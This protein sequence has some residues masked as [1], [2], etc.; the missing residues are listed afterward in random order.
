MKSVI[1]CFVILICFFSCGRTEK[2]VTVIP[3]DIAE[4]IEVNPD[5][6][7]QRLNALEI[8]P[9]DEYA[10][11]RYLLYY[12]EAK[13]KAQKD[14]SIDIDVISAFNYFKT[15]GD[16]CNAAL[17]AYYSGRVLQS[18]KDYDKAMKYYQIAESYA[19]Q[20]NDKDFQGLSLYAMADLMLN[21]LLFQDA[22]QKLEEAKA[23]FEQINNQEYIIKTYKLMAI[24]HMMY[25]NDGDVFTLYNQALNKARQFKDKE[26]E[27]LIMH[28]IGAFYLEQKEYDKSLQYLEAST[29]IDSIVYKSGMV[30]FSLGSAYL[31]KGDYDSADYYLNQSLDWIN[32]NEAGNTNRFTFIYQLLSDLEE[33]RRN[34]VLAL[35]YHKHYSFYF[36]RKVRENRNSGIANAERKYRFDIIKDENRELELKQLELQKMLLVLLLVLAV[37]SAVYYRILLKKNRQLNKA[38]LEISS[39]AEDV[40]NI[41][42]IKN[43]LDATHRV[44]EDVL[45]H[46]FGVLKRAASLEYIVQTSGD[47]QS[48]L[49]IR[50]FNEIA[51]G[52]DK[53]EW[54]VLYSIMNAM[55]H[56]FLDKIKAKYIDVLDEIEFQLCCLTYSRMNAQEISVILQLSVYTVHAKTTVIRKKLGVEKYGNI[57]DFLDHAIN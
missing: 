11:S 55:L 54:D 26:E 14:I 29:V 50:K 23:L 8:N 38:N 53:V 43:D 20:N 30:F 3:Q 44:T 40:V 31:K 46:S 27:A 47:K 36:A 22:T 33:K 4:L 45:N 34:Y 5:S 13:D 21:Q 10:Y 24:C 48:K 19:I 16:L 52:N 17:A 28:D 56:G 25:M 57:V 42:K 2:T 18:S 7:L 32:K 39:L 9:G 49:L 6:A 41:G 12:V 51:Y 35:A 37:S 1:Y 15:K